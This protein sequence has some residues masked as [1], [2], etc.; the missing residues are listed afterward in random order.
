MLFCEQCQVHVEGALH[1]CPLCQGPLS[2]QP[3]ENAYPVLPQAKSSLGLSLRLAALATVAVAAVCF[4]VNYS[5]PHTGWWSVFVFAALASTWLVLGVTVRKRGSPM[6]AVVWQ[7]G[8]ISAVTLLWDLCTGFAGWSL[9]FVLPIFIPCAQLAAFIVVKALG[10]RPAE[11]LFCLTIC[12]LVGFVPLILLLCG[13]LGTV[14]PSVICVS[15]SLV[16]LAGLLLIKG[17]ELK[18]DAVRRLHL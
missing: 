18:D 14:Y 10:L 3:G 2:G 13:T 16:A 9:D 4:A 5:L 1:R 8:V 12:I 15:I 6:K 17:K 11:Y 7:L